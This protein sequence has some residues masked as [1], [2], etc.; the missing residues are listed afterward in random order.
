MLCVSVYLCVLYVCL[1]VVCIVYICVFLCICV[2]YV[3][4]V[5]VFLCVLCMCVS[6]CVVSMCVC[7]C[8]TWKVTVK[9]VSACVLSLLAQPD[10]LGTCKPSEGE[11]AWGMD[12]GGLSSSAHRQRTF[13]QCLDPPGPFLFVDET[14]GWIQGAERSRRFLH[15]H[16]TRC[17]W[18]LTVRSC[19]LC[20]FPAPGAVRAPG[21]GLG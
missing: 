20:L 6:V 19:C 13:E 4:F 10:I 7:V 9:Q 17:S 12:C 18:L 3:Y 14:R 11:L 5:L 21:E 1:C 15:A 16:R 8:R 2:Y